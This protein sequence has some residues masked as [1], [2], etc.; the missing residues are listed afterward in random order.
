[1]GKIKKRDRIDISCIAGM[2]PKENPIFAE[3]KLLMTTVKT[4]LADF[5]RDQKQQRQ[6]IANSSNGEPG[7]QDGSSSQW[8]S[9]TKHKLFELAT[10]QKQLLTLFQCHKKLLDKIQALKQKA[11]SV[12]KHIIPAVE[13]YC[14]SKRRVNVQQKVMDRNTQQQS[15][16]NMCISNTNPLAVTTCENTIPNITTKQGNE[17]SVSKHTSFPLINVISSH[18]ENSCSAIPSQPLVTSAV[19]QVT[20]SSTPV[21]VFHNVS[22]A[23]LTTPLVISQPRVQNVVL[24]AAQLYQVGGRQIY[25]L[26]QV[27]SATT[28]FTV[29]QAAKL[30]QVTAKLPSTT[31]TTSA[32]PEMGLISSLSVAISAQ[33]HPL[34]T[35]VSLPSTTVSWLGQSSQSSSQVSSI[36]TAVPSS[37]VTMPNLDISSHSNI[38][39]PV[40][41]ARTVNN[42][43]AL[44]NATPPIACDIGSQANKHGSHLNHKAPISC[45]AIESARTVPQ[46]HKSA[47][48]QSQH[49]IPTQNAVGVQS[50]SQVTMTTEAVTSKGAVSIIVHGSHLSIYLF[51]D[52]SFNQRS[53]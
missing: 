32:T 43:L 23:S 53:V 11:R 38:S 37:S 2:T 33:G 44:Q 15:L 50:S 10:Q 8:T 14:K 25:V 52:S 31:Y 28:T 45:A 39:L 17:L 35:E 46:L 27:L 5:T 6:E 41:T 30:Q 16:L 22:T 9:Q 24:T 3:V 34:N 40:S 49:G 51:H 36:V 48:L 1:M 42:S 19:T 29:T 18:T 13:V 12:T 21:T 47:R 4:Q 26:P 20:T 7:S